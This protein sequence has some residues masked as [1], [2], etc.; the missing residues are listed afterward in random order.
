MLSR[1]CQDI[2]DRFC[3]YLDAT[4]VVVAIADDWAESVLWLW[5]ILELRRHVDRV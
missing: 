1:N 4:I 5:L 3:S 2:G